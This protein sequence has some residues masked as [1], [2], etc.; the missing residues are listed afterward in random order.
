MDLDLI[1]KRLLNSVYPT[2]IND[3]FFLTI[4]ENHPNASMQVPVDYQLKT[5]SNFLESFF[6]Y[7]GMGPRIF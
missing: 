6:N 2:Q 7:N 3:F 5:W 4:P 1:K